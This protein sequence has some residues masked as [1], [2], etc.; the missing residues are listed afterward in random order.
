MRPGVGA[1]QETVNH[2][3]TGTLRVEEV[4]T[5]DAFLALER[6]WNALLEGCARREV[7]LTHDWMAA[8]WKCLGSDKE[9]V[10][11]LV[12]SG[13]EMIGIAPFMQVKD[14]FFGIPR[15]RLEFITMMEYA[16]S[17]TNCS[18]TLDII[19]PA[20]HDEVV[21][22]I[23]EHLAG[24]SGE[25]DFI[26]LHPIPDESVGMKTFEAGA[27]MRGYRVHKENLYVNFYIPVSGDWAGYASQ[28][29]PRFSKS[30]RSQ[31]RKLRQ[32][33][34]VQ[35]R[36]AIVDGANGEIDRLYEEILGIEQ[37]SWKWNI[38]VSLN[39]VH[40]KDFYRV[41]A[42]RAA[43]RGWLRVWIMQIDGRDVAYDYILDYGGTVASLKT[44]YDDTYRAYSP[45]NLLSWHEFQH[46]FEIGKKQI[47]LLWGDLT[48][49]QR[50]APA[51]ERHYEMFLFPASARGRFWQF[52]SISCSLMKYRRILTGWRNR[53]ARKLGLRLK[54]SELTRIDQLRSI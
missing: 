29:S 14:R 20:R 47:A 21:S 46:F 3:H 40:L 2:T 16:D 28:L 25:W 53:V 48:T 33:G 34:D 45:G 4:R 43:L 6:E 30:L 36:E 15:R 32:R 51:V 35:F 50:W 7:Y 26:R 37:K 13:D 11:L 44:S 8:W 49:K 39:S 42:R 38:G 23:L 27:R 52:L 17:P 5:R 31:E 54:S 12:R 19:V 41:L 24:I 22:A 18:A 10:I 9:L 1:A